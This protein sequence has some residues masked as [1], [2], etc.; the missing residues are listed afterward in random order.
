MERVCGS[1][2]SSVWV[3]RWNNAIRSERTVRNLKDK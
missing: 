1:G 3:C 2:R